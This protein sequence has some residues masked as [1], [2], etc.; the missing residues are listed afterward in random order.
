[1][2][3][4]ELH[5]GVNKELAGAGELTNKAAIEKWWAQINEWRAQD[6]LKYDRSSDVIKPQYVVEELY[7]ATNG[8]AFITSDVGQHQMFAAQYYGFDRPRQW[9]NSGGLGTM[10][11]GLPAAIGAQF[12]ARDHLERSVRLDPAY[13]PAQAWLE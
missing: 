2:V 5:G 8:E 9:I 12:A 13:A 11:Y 10:G 7:N 4:Q 6:C 3:L 1:M